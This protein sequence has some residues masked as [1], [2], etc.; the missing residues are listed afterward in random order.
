MIMLMLKMILQIIFSQYHIH[1]NASIQI[2]CKY[3]EM[4]MFLLKVIL[5][6]GFSQYLYPHK[7]KDTK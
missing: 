3:E 1:A 4:I 2:T 5:Q 6:N 7:C